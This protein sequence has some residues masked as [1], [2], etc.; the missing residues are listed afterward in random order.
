[1][2]SKEKKKKRSKKTSFVFSGIGSQWKTMGAELYKTEHIFRQ[3][4]ETCDHLFRQYTN[5]SIVEEIGRNAHNSRITNS[6]IA[7]PCIFSIQTALNDLLIHW[8]VKPD[9]LIGHSGGEIAA[10]HC[11]GV[12]S[13]DDAIHL[14]WQHNIIMQQVI[15]KGK[16]AHIAVPV[17]RLEEYLTT[18][19]KHISVAAINSP[20]ATVLTGDEEVLHELISIFEKNNIFC[21]MLRIDIPFHS[22][23]IEPYME[24][25]RRSLS[26]IQVHP[27]TI[28]IYSSYR[29]AFHKENDFHADYWVKHIRE[30][31]LFA[32]SMNAMI[33]DGY[34]I[35]IEISPHPVLSASMHECFQE[36]KIKNYLIVDTLKRHESEKQSVLA[37]MAALD[38]SGLEV[39]WNKMNTAN[40]NAGKILI[41]NLKDKDAKVKQGFTN[42]SPQERQ[43]KLIDLI[44]TIIDD[45]SN[46]KISPI[47]TQTGFLA[48][49][50]TSL[51]AVHLIR[52]LE[53]EL[54][55][56]IPVT[57]LFDY[58]NVESFSHYL[59]SRIQNA[60]FPHLERLDH[61]AKS[62]YQNLERD[63]QI[64]VVGMNCRFPGGADNPNAFW[65]LLV[66]R[67]SG[68]N[69]IP[70]TRWN[71][72][73]YDDYFSDNPP[74]AFTKW[75]H[76]LSDFSV[77]DF[78]A[79]FFNVSP[80]EVGSLDPQ[81]RLILETSWQAF[82][83]AG[84]AVS[85]LKDRKVGV[86]VGICTFDF[87]SSVFD[88]MNLD[89]MNQYSGSGAMFSC[90]AGR[91]SYFMNLQGPNLAVDTACSSSLVALDLACQALNHNKAE[92][93][94]V[95]GVNLLLT[96]QL[97][98]YFNKLGALSPDG[99]C[100]SFDASADG[101]ARGEG[102]GV[103]ILKKLSK[104]LIDGDNILAVI[105]GT[106]VNHDGASSSFTAPNGIAQ[107]HVIREALNNA[108]VLPHK[109]S[110]VETHGTGT[111]L[112]DPI[113]VNALGEIYAN[114]HHKKQ[115]LI[116]GSVKANIGHLEGAAGISGLIKT[117]LCLNNE[118]IPGQINFNKPNPHIFW[119]KLP[120]QI[121]TETIP[122]PRTNTPRIAGISSFGFSGTNA[123]VIIEE[124]PLLK[125]TK[126]NVERPDHILALSAKSEKALYSLI[127]RYETYLDTTT[128]SIENICYTASIG[129]T[130]FNYRLSVSGQSKKDI[131]EKLIT[132]LNNQSGVVNASQENRKILFLFTAQNP[133]YE[134]MGQDLYQTQ[135][136]FKKALDIC[137]HLF[138]PYINASI[139]KILYDHPDSETMIHNT[140][141]AQT[142]LFSI[143]YALLELWRSWGIHPSI[144]AGH[145]IGE[146][147]V[148]YAADIINLEDAVKLSAARA[149]FM[150]SLPENER[151]DSASHT[152][153]ASKF[154]KF[155]KIA[156]EIQYSE[157]NLP[158]IS[159]ETGKQVSGN[160]L[161]CAEYWTEQIRKT[162]TYLEMMTYLGDSDIVLEMGVY[163]KIAA[164]DM[165]SIQTF[166]GVWL[167]SLIKKTN[168]YDTIFESLGR[169]YQ[170]KAAIDWHGFD[171]PYQRH[172]IVLPNY[173]F[174]RKRYENSPILAKNRP[175][176][177]VN[178]HP[179]IGRK[180]IS[181]ALKDTIIFDSLFTDDQPDFLKEHIIFDHIIS[182]AAAHIAM[183]LSAVNT[184]FYTHQCCIEDVDFIHPLIVNK[185][186]KR[187]VQ[188]IFENTTHH[189]MPYKIVSCAN[190]N[191]E[192]IIHC[193]GKVMTDHVS[194]EFGEKLE[195][196]SDAIKI[197]CQQHINGIDF[198][199]K[200][201]SAG[202]QLGKHF[203]C[204]DHA[205]CGDNEA[206]C[207]LNVFPDTM[208]FKNGNIH[209][210]L[211][212]SILQSAM[213][214]SIQRLATI[215]SNNKILIPLN[216]SSFKLFS[217]DFTTSIQTYAK[218]RRKKDVLESD[219][220]GWNSHGKLL[221]EIKN[222]I[223]KETDKEILLKRKNNLDQLFYSIEWEEKQETDMPDKKIDI[224]A[225]L[226]FSDNSGTG[227]RLSNELKN[228]NIDC[229]HVFKGRS[230]QQKNTHEYLVNPT[231]YE[232]FIH[233]FDTLVQD[234]FLNMLFFW[235]L[236]TEL[237]D[238]TSGLS[239]DKDL[240]FSCGSLLHLTQ[241]IINY[242]WKHI[243]KLW[244]I[245]S[246][247]CDRHNSK[248]PVNASQS[249]LW[250]MGRAIALEHPELWGGCCDLENTISALSMETL[251]KET[252]TQSID[253][254]ICL[255]E[256]GISYVPRLKHYSMNELNKESTIKSDATY[257][258][259]G[260]SGALGLLSARWLVN[261]GCKHLVLIGRNIKKSDTYRQLKE[262]RHPYI[263][264]L[265]TQLDVSDK[266]ALVSLFNKIQNEMPPIKGIIHTAGVLDDGMLIQQNWT[267]FQNVMRAKV[268]GS[269]NLHQLTQNMNLDFFV[270]FS[271]A[272]SITG[273]KGQG[274]Y[275][276]ANAFMDG[277]AHYRNAKALP[278][279]SINW[280][281]WD[282]G[283]AALDKDVQN[284][285][286]N[287][288]F[289]L[290][291]PEMGL[292]ALNQV[293]LEDMVQIG[294][295]N[296]DL[297]TFV[298]KYSIEKIGFFSHL[299]QSKARI[300]P[301]DQ[302]DQ[303]GILH[304]LK[305]ALPEQRASMMLSFLKEMTV[306]ITGDDVRIDEPLMEQGFD[307]LM[308][309]ELRNSLNEILKQT[310]PVSLLFDYP[311]LEM[312]VD[313]LIKDILQLDTSSKPVQ[314]ESESRVN[315]QDAADFL[316]EIEGLI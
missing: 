8:G 147:L 28:P 311:S 126:P 75:A 30:K 240:E 20:N 229:I 258:I 312:V 231:S 135:P 122:W 94:L 295:M 310:L 142:A 183:V 63:T 149:D 67:K 205:W 97:F 313:Y 234:K 108:R 298:N 233:L 207:E 270:M 236:D 186:Q 138:N 174:Q 141:Y 111:A 131:R 315:I 18:Y 74:E 173:P 287:Q 104:A 302:S 211:I 185:N 152:F 162:E 161:M 178:D 146:Y 17:Q 144:L 139:V 60:L 201:A 305:N 88:Q 1:M 190:P 77:S 299:V 123:H 203:Q 50:L 156:S 12:L 24:K 116:I 21:R 210:G 292:E 217:N 291:Q 189:N 187:N 176:L 163:S 293:L 79:G 288:G 3:K 188:I 208:D 92:I 19:Q 112:G 128:E 150:Q 64:A 167:S 220:I 37:S 182:P 83:N 56:S 164:Q 175:E 224:P 107:Q 66:N 261:S 124:A 47:D 300:K 5:L 65:Q 29:G 202:Y 32:N 282:A 9:A 314:E 93:A 280:G 70:D 133:P 285:I 200:F 197:R 160:E 44:T 158:I 39:H 191:E 272:A 256:N 216:I 278:A 193:E 45:V 153:Y 51:M 249:V 157:P 198:H 237:S 101:Y 78:D 54:Q 309:V 86:Y 276:A 262:L 255:D 169:F 82:E 148:A 306:E 284:K 196:S 254:Q 257:L 277:L 58:P 143:E 136:V 230:F 40:Q 215:V 265:E 155:K 245:T 129:R 87:Q 246:H 297:N 34:R 100:K 15:G 137:D 219:I 6:L 251:L 264:V 154:E 62:R 179:L 96:P 110:Y 90:A 304:Q 117:I 269:W 121:P 194:S 263:Q 7:Q 242:K 268:S 267:R 106:A 166:S 218:S 95:A 53:S 199:N 303:S 23:F 212:D 57:V 41:K 316:D 181:P 140:V 26:S 2:N 48:M 222:F 209:P 206:I 253:D 238:D 72:E 127:K 184:N 91:L 235:G 250:G 11:A 84:I 283:M 151:M 134:G 252:T 103:V 13:L 195:F 307:S 43:Q 105:K 52:A 266:D 259:T 98:V 61:N 241:S 46:G 120:I 118:Y 228:K 159:N 214:T 286:F 247:A 22:H 49:G 145:S 227:T 168:N 248:Y 115:P 31:V 119:D 244:I 69:K 114:S 273:N 290:I 109:L 225:Y 289:Q 132:H 223:L 113:E 243:P 85:E 68:R 99:V 27:A 226:I 294:I 55:L 170:H 171:A 275:A 281:P 165:P 279:T 14:V 4:I 177:T 10:T 59:D 221:F 125:E 274:N 192:W 81:Q 71:I 271:S 308:A 76:F 204:I 102:C 25:C 33:N 130:H 301:K 38:L 35:F 16:M 172:K 213:L 232:D 239:I 73:K 80:K 260:G 36:H 180:V 89:R 296:C 42:V